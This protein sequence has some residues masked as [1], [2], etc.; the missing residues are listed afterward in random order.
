[1]RQKEEYKQAKVFKGQIIINQLQAPEHSQLKPSSFLSSAV[2]KEFRN[3][4][5][6]FKRKHFRLESTI[7]YGVQRLEVPAWEE[8]MPQC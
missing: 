5:R 8:F 3:Y 4:F 7:G 6:K 2:S 1:M